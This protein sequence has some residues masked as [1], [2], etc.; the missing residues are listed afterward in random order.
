MIVVCT[1]IQWD[2]IKWARLF[3]ATSSFQAVVIGY[4]PSKSNPG[5]TGALWVKMANGKKF[6]V[7]SG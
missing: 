3:I 7:G 1:A 2:E 5:L 4:E 6:K